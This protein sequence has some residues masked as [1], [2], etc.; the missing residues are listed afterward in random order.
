VP[1]QQAQQPPSDYQLAIETALVLGTAVTVADALLPLAAYFGYAKIRRA[2]LRAA[3]ES[4]M[5]FPPER[6]GAPGP[7]TL[8][9]IRLNTMRRAQFLVAAARRTENDLR[10]GVSQNRNLAQVISLA[11]AREKR[12]YALHMQAAWNRASAAAKV[13][14]TAGVYG[15]LLG[16]YSVLD[17]RT[18]RECRAAAGRNF[19]ADRMPLIGYPGSVHPH[20]RCYPG[21]PHEGAKLLS[22]AGTLRKVMIAA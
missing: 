6:L 11:M 13:D 14:S 22:S 1:P 20:C 16:W 10:E 5:S 15:L 8:T 21:R 9:A 4:V 19:W 7:A 17:S 12:Y 18:S 3:L 2:A